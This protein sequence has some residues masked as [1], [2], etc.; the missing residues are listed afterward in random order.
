MGNKDKMRDGDATTDR[1]HSR[2]QESRDA[3]LARTIAVAVAGVLAQQ[4]SEETQSIA[5][6]V[7]GALAKQKAEVT[8]SIT[9]AFTRQMEKTHA[10]YE[11][12]LKETRAQALPSTLKVTSGTD[13]SRVMDPFD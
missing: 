5:K 6:A 12:L 11:K 10:Q 9:E 1:D 8:Q 13:G 4:K 3:V 7:A 2:D